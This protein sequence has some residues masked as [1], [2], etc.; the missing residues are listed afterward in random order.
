MISENVQGAIAPPP[1]GRAPANTGKKLGERLKYA[2]C[3]Y[4]NH[5]HTGPELPLDDTCR[6]ILTI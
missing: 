2:T 6:Q 1:H 5:R 3:L 4:E